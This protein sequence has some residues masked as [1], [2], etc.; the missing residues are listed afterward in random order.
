MTM[1]TPQPRRRWF[2]YSLRTLFVAVTLF[3][4]WLGWELKFIR[5]RNSLRDWIDANGFACTAAEASP[6]LPPGEQLFDPSPRRVSIPM[7]RQ[8]LGD[9]AIA[10]IG[11]GKQSPT[12]ENWQN[13]KRLFPEA[14]W[15]NES[16]E[17]GPTDQ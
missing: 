4:V 11:I 2:G 3:A 7:W 9:E 16:Y 1:P 6:D 15:A 5:E 12:H 8:W 17:W 10:Y 14:W 13:A